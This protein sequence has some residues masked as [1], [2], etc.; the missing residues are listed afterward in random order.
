MRRKFSSEHLS[1]LKSSI[2]YLIIL[3]LVLDDY[4]IIITIHYQ[5]NA[6]KQADHV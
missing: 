5:T 2:R 6:S 4:Q 1:F 3:K